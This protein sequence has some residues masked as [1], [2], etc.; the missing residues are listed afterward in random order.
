MLNENMGHHL[1]LFSMNFFFFGKNTHIPSNYHLIVNVPPKLPI[2]SM[3]PSNYQKM[4]MSPSKINKKTKMT[5]NFF[6][7]DKN[8]LINSKKKKIKLKLKNNNNNNNK[9]IDF[10]KN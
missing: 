7:Y 4:S 5:L 3:S 2:V 8:V 6:K 10:F 1:T 9:K